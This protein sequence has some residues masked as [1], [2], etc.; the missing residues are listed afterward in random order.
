MLRLRTA[1]VKPPE[2]SEKRAPIATLAAPQQLGGIS[3]AAEPHVSGG[4]LPPVH[5]FSA[6]RVFDN[7]R[8][9][10]PK[11]TI[12]KAHDPLE[13]EADRV[14]ELAVGPGR[15]P[16]AVDSAGARREIQRACDQCRKE[17]EERKVQRKSNAAPEAAI[18]PPAVETALAQ[19]GRAMDGRTRAFFEKR[20]AHDFATVRVHAGPQ[21]AASARAIGAIAYTVGRDIVLGA[22]A[23]P[24]ETLEGRRLL[25]HELTHV[26][27]QG[28]AGPGIVQRQPQPAP[29][30][31]GSGTDQPPAPA[32][33]PKTP[34]G[35]DL[36]PTDAN[37]TFCL[38]STGLVVTTGVARNDTTNGA[39]G[40]QKMRFEG[41]TGGKVDGKSCACECGLYRHYIRGHINVSRGS[42]PQRQSAAVTQIGSCNQPLAL[43]P[44]DF[45]EEAT[46]CLHLPD[47]DPAHCKFS[48]G[49]QP[50]TNKNT[51]L[52]NGTNIDLKEDFQYEV[53]DVCQG[54]SVVQKQKTL[55]IQGDAAPRAITWT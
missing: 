44:T 5:R 8:C 23:Q 28:A 55:S 4:E 48:L 41:V 20:F 45:H 33:N 35:V 19:P 18:A 21:A 7:A 47:H 43:D 51:A 39:Q 30:S 42:G 16:L 34:D 50:G 52:A 22:E 2:R 46:S 29:P 11:L 12:G 14:A 49:D 53:W 3:R 37:K 32:A 31:S 38:K 13:Q 17:E 15:S 10:Q 40:W 24:P 36:G 25:A 54:K 6:I 26:V 1:A 9:I 27:Q